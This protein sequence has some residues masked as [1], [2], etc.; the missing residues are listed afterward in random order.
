MDLMLCWQQVTAKCAKFASNH[1]KK[2]IILMFRFASQM[3]RKYLF[4]G[5]CLQSIPSSLQVSTGCL[6]LREL[7]RAQW[8]CGEVPSCPVVSSHSNELS[9]TGPAS[10]NHL[11]YVTLN[12]SSFS[13][14]VGHLIFLNSSLLF[15]AN[16][17]ELL[18]LNTLSFHETV[19][20]SVK[21]SC[22]QCD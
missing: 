18:V 13:L 17:S 6:I 14:R 15:T 2:N 21:F 3:V 4:W 5:M 9:L 19:S 7:L 10:T 22:L 20:I 8:V 1:A 12:I 11:H 16:F